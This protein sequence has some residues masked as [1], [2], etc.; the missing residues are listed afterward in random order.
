[1]SSAGGSPEACSPTPNRSA[2]SRAPRSWISFYPTSTAMNLSATLPATHNHAPALHEHM[3][4]LG[5]HLQHCREAQG[6]FARLN[7]LANDMHG[8]VAPRFVTTLAVAGVVI[9]LICA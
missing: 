9:A 6:R 1:M 7:L 5:R 2:L 4:S 3:H 8:W